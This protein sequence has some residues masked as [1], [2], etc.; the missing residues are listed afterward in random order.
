MST[1]TNVASIK[2]SPGIGIGRVGNS[3]EYFIG[4][5]T[6]SVVPEPT[7][8]PNTPSTY[9]D[10]TGAIK[11][12][13]QRFRVYGYDSDGNCLGEITNGSSVNGSVVTINWQTHVTN[14]KAANYAFQGKYAFNPEDLRNSTVQPGLPPNQRDKLIIDPGPISI[15][16]VSQGPVELL[17][18][19][20]GGSKIFD[21]EGTSELS[22]RLQFD[23]PQSST[24]NVVVTYT[25]ATV[26]LGKLHTDSEGRLIFIGGKGIS[27]SCTTPKVVISKVVVAQ[28]EEPNPEY[29]GNSYFNN[30]GWYD[31]TCG[32][33]INASLLASDGTELFSTNDNAA[34]RGWIAI[35]P[36]HYA[37]AANNVVSLLDLQLDIFPSADP[38]TGKGPFY[39]AQNVGGY[40]ALASSE[41]GDASSLN[42]STISTSVSSSF[43]PAVIRFQ[44]QTYVAVIDSSGNPQLGI[45]NSDGTFTFSKVSSSVT[46]S[47]APALSVLNN[48]LYYAINSNGT[49]N[50]G[51]PDGQGGYTF[52]PLTN[53]YQVY[54]AQA[55]ALTSFNG[56]LYYA[57]ASTSGELLLASSQNNGD[58]AN[59]SF[60]KITIPDVIIGLSSLG[61]TVY[62][63]KLYVGYIGA[64]RTLYLLKSS[65]GTNFT[66]DHEFIGALPTGSADLGV[67]LSSF[68]NQLFYA[69]AWTTNGTTQTQLA[70]SRD[71][72]TFAFDPVNSGGQSAPSI[73]TNIPVNFYRD[74]YPILKTVTDYA[75]TNER[76]FHGHRPGTS[77]DFLNPDYLPVLASPDY[78][79]E[80]F[81]RAFVFSFIRPP[82][83][84]VYAKEGDKTVI[85]KVPPVPAPAPANITAGDQEQR[86]DLMPRLFGNGG[87]VE[88]NQTNGTN[89]PNQ[90]LPLTNHQLEKFQQWVNGNFETGQ[91]TDTQ[92]Q[93]LPEDQQR[94][95]AALQPTVGGGFHPGIELTYLMHEA[96][97]FN[98]PFRFTQETLPGS[99][100]AYM[101]VPWQGDFWS[102]NISWWPALR[103]DIVVERTDDTPPVLSHISWF[104]GNEI[105]PESDSISGYEGGYNVMVDTWKELGFVTP[106]DGL[107]DQGQQVFQ[108]TERAASLNTPSILVSINNSQLNSGNA[109]TNSN[110]SL[111]V[112]TTDTSSTTQQWQLIESKSSAGYFFIQDP[113]SKDVLTVDFASGDVSLTTQ[114]VPQQDSQLWQY[115]PAGYPGHFTLTSKINLQL[116]SV[117]S[118]SSVNTSAAS[119]SLLQNWLLQASS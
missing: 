93:G 115:T 72:E 96:A 4:P 85:V 54:A 37:P 25:G 31:D 38:N 51:A 12:Q 112:Q 63:G 75:W 49:L 23:P 74:I 100:A 43:A 19:T 107:F 18:S 113:T 81:A 9:K 57:T 68:N 66:Y 41:T 11:R 53:S 40:P 24:G 69:I 70:I 32:G 10:S 77:G 28:S 46:A 105:P 108:E 97:F 27:E 36:P 67:S 3:D 83:Q 79:S 58:A 91:T 65:D 111:I 89:Y 116:L 87:S 6:P 119:T 59:F 21:I 103:P 16:G 104:R 82:A 7:T 13:A 73:S 47:A 110:G 22:S 20:G 117:Q 61:L 101:S 86:A 5:E 44:E 52:S 35:A 90:W 102:C 64:D 78:S 42:F 8:G 109:L 34:Q 17:D 95:F 45:S 15:S 14:M 114:E 80:Q 62:A 1:L 88:E 50:I 118:D 2:V 71:G 29:N 94:S 76:A 92:W 99:I 98:S 55:P 33:S 60:S 84:N 39:F 48:Q 26:S 56:S 30:P 106:V